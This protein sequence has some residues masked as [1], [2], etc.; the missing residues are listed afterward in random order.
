MQLSLSNT[1]SNCEKICWET[2]Q[3][4]IYAILWSLWKARNDIIFR[5]STPDL[6]DVVDIIKFRVAIW[7]KGTRNLPIYS[8]KDFKTA[9]IGLGDLFCDVLRCYGFGCCLSFFLITFVFVSFNSLLDDF[10]WRVLPAQ[11]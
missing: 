9:S 5:N 1:Y 10:F 6:D 4:T 2:G 11:D 8:I 7:V 3:T